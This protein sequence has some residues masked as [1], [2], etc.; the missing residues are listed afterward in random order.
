VPHQASR[1]HLRGHVQFSDV[2]IS[3]M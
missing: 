3:Y 1:L 2:M